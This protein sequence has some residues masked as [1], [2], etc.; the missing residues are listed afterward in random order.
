MGENRCYW[1]TV[2]GQC[3]DVEFEINPELDNLKTDNRKT[4]K[5]NGTGK[6]SFEK[7]LKFAFENKD[8]NTFTMKQFYDGFPF[9]NGADKMFENY[10][11]KG[12]FTV[13]KDVAVIV[14]VNEQ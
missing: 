13:E 5:D 8:R 1:S 9:E 7:T 11:Q 3:A 14:R 4:R 10:C 2:T 6:E 12:Y